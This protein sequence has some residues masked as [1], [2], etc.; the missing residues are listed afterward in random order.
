MARATAE[1]TCKTC[2]KVFYRY[3]VKKNS[4]EARAYEEWAAKNFDECDE[5]RSARIEAERAEHERECREAAASHGWPE[6]EGTPKQ[7]AWAVTIREEK[8]GAAVEDAMRRFRNDAERRAVA[9]RAVEEVTCEQVSA[10]FW[11]DDRGQGFRKYEEMI[12]R[13]IDEIREG[14][15][16]PEPV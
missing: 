8:H 11:I 9:L 14:R 15:P 13:R 7:V 5:C 12:A 16:E 10:K 6:L 2:G 4:A 3:A 1:C